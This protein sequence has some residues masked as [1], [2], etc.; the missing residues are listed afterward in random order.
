NLFYEEVEQRF[1]DEVCRI[2]NDGGEDQFVQTLDEAR[3]VTNDNTRALYCELAPS[4]L[5]LLLLAVGLALIFD[6]LG[7]LS[8]DGVWS[9]TR[10]ANNLALGAGATTAAAILMLAIYRFSYTHV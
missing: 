9:P 10:V 4:L 1:I 7:L 8:Q 6:P 3:R 2:D 5:L